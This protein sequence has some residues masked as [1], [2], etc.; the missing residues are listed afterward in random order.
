VRNRFAVLGAK[1]LY[2][3]AA[4]GRMATT[5]PST[6]SSAT[7]ASTTRSFQAEGRA[8]PEASA[9]LTI[10]R[11]ERSEKL[12][13]GGGEVADPG[14]GR[15]VDGVDDRGAGAANS[16]LADALAA[17]RAAVGIVGPNLSL[18]GSLATILWLVVLRR[19]GLEVGAW[20]FLRLG[21]FVM[22]P[23][24]VLS[25]KLP[26]RVP[27]GPPPFPL[28][29]SFAIGPLSTPTELFQSGGDPTTSTN[30]SEI[31]LPNASR[32]RAR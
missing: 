5:S 20:S 19:E 30:S 3:D 4:R 15:I 23:A 7:N 25:M 24:L 12:V 6:A 8:S 27:G 17:E 14:A 32:T 16:Q 11:L 21:I 2:I 18:T 29:I 10:E 9:R 28:P 26:F 22:P 31:V 13:R 1:T